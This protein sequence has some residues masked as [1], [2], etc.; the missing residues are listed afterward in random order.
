M[1]VV[2]RSDTDDLGE[3]NVLEIKECDQTISAFGWEHLPL[4]E[5]TAFGIKKERHVVTIEAA[6][7]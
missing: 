6:K 4:D 2:S 7:V 5:G 3:A 1:Q